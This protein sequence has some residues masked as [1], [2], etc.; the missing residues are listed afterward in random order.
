[1]SAICIFKFILTSQFILK[2]QS[3]KKC[4]QEFLSPKAYLQI[5]FWNKFSKLYAKINSWLVR[6]IFNLLLNMYFT[7][8]LVEKL[9]KLWLK[10]VHYLQ[11]FWQTNQLSSSL[12]KFLQ[13]VFFKRIIFKKMPQVQP[14]R[15]PNR[16]AAEA[17]W[18]IMFVS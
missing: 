1:M 2:D 7:R 9:L 15:C 8:Q 4:C 10:Y 14:E 16:A 3:K 17:G 6:R 5:Y 18:Y 11:I 12:K 13:Y